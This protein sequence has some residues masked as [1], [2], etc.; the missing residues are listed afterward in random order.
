MIAFLL[1]CLASVG[2]TAILVD[3]KIFA[4][5]RQRLAER[6]ELSRRRS[7]K[8]GREAGWSFSECLHGIL[9]CYQCCGFW[10][11]L[12]CGLFL[13]PDES[14]VYVLL[15]WFCCGAAGSIL[16]HVY[17]MFVELIFAL[18]ML[19]RSKT[20]DLR[21]HEHEHRDEEYDNA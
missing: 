1:F 7:E 13:I 4:G 11:G 2:T 10:S 14:L 18:T 5:F 6:I 15:F 3:G 12:F 16:A 9:G 19:V 20:P 8:S 17:L 21:P